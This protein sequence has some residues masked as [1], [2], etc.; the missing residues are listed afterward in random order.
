MIRN[1][2]H[3]MSLAVSLLFM[4]CLLGCAISPGHRFYSGSPL[5]SNEIALVFTVTGCSIF[6][7]RD[8]TENEGKIIGPRWIWGPWDVLDLLPGRYVAGITYSKASE[9]TSGALKIRDTTTGRRVQTELR[10]QAGNIYVIYP[11]FTQAMERE[12]W[13]PIFENLNDYSQDKCQKHNGPLDCYEKDR[14]WKLATEYLQ[15]ERTTMSYHPL[16]K[17][18]VWE[19]DGVRRVVS[20]IWR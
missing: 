17:P 11:A 14:I 6:D 5:P 18:F 15:S 3:K 8:E 20:G 16:E 7:I 2:K 12:K 13:S 10:V 4:S 1:V 19:S 9:S